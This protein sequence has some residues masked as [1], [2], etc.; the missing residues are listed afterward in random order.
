MEAAWAGT[1]RIEIEDAVFLFNLWLMAVAIDDHVKSG[2]FRL[3]VESSEIVQHINGDSADFD[4]FDLRESAC[5][6]L[7]V[8]VAADR[9]Y[10][11]GLLQRLENFGS[12]DIA[13]VKD[14]PANAAVTSGRSRPCVSEITPT[15]TGF[16]SIGASI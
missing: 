3:Q 11:R 6:S 13:C 10:R 4:D 15:V 9:G 2:G 5:P 8:E 7:G 16:S 1:P 14:A 12:A